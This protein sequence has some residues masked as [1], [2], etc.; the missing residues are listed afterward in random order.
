MLDKENDAENCKEKEAVIF[1]A[2]NCP[3]EGL[4]ELQNY[5]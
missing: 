2:L 5:L 1:T 4:P 3:Q